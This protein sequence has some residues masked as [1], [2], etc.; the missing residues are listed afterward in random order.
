MSHFP[1]VLSKLSLD[2]EVLIINFHIFALLVKELFPGYALLCLAR[3]KVIGNFQSVISEQIWA[4][5][6][7]FYLVDTYQLLLIFYSAFL[8]LGKAFCYL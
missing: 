6:L 5:L 7:N 2:D 1:V 4:T 8:I 3:S